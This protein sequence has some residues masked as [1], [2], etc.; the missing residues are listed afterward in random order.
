MD[1]DVGVVA[2][3]LAGQQRLELAAVA[4]GLQRL[5]RAQALGLGRFVALG[6][7][8]FD[9][10]RSVLEV[11]GNLGERTEPV[12]EHC[13]LAHQLLRGLGVVPEARIFGF[14]VE[15]G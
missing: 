8:E 12:L 14:G 15:F 13:A 9:Q 11:A 1:L 2:V 7:A 3:G 6:L 5:Q 10:R 4:L